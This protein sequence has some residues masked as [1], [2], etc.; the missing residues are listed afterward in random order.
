[1]VVGKFE[2]DC[3]RPTLNPNRTS[4]TWIERGV[5]NDS[6][7]TMLTT[8]RM[9]RGVAIVAL[10]IA[11][12]GCTAGQVS[13]AEV[14]NAMRRCLAFAFESAAAADLSDAERLDISNTVCSRILEDKGEAEFV[15]EYENL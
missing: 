6:I 14:D 15:K 2:L 8:M 11:I 1:M 5:S 3:S 13:P 9:L 4:S 10:A 7:W 12:C